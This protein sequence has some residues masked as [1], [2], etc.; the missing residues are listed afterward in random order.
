MAMTA[1]LVLLPQPL[2]ASG[3]HFED[4]LADVLVWVVLAI[5][6]LI[7]IGIFLAVHI[8]PEKVAENRGH[9]QLDA[10]KTVC[11][12]SLFF[13]GILWPL[14]WVWAYSKPVMYKLAYGKD[15][16]EP[17]GPGGSDAHDAEAGASAVTPAAEAEIQHLRR[18][19]AELEAPA[20]SG[21]LA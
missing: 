20:R 17:H 15:R 7:G 1:A 16:V 18:R 3:G 19:L 6:P 2:L 14:A 13:G 11:L 10:I 12:L 4:K 9:P 21:R 5:A 8:L